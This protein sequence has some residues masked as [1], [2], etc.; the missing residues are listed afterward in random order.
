L[1]DIAQNV[2]SNIV[3]NDVPLSDMSEDITDYMIENYKG[4]PEIGDDVMEMFGL[5]EYLIEGVKLEDLD[6]I[7]NFDE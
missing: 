4:R 5:D 1:E 3:I 7:N 2:A 6:Y